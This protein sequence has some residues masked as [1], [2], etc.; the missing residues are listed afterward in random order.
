MTIRGW[1]D[2]WQPVFDSLGRMRACWPTRGWSW[3]P[4]LLCVTSSFTT[5]QEPAA[6]TATQMA[7]QNEW[8]T[9]T[10]VRAPQLLREV[11]DRAGG[12]R[13]GQLALSTGP[14]NGLLVYG[15]WWPWGDGETVSLR[16]G[17]ADVDPNREP[18]IRF[19]DVFGVTF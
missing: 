3:D 8:T 16:V 18:Y 6:R 9:A 19:R 1:N 5:E 2:A 12:I 14:I 4:R 11:V 7:L 13:Q 15:L 17:L 10:L